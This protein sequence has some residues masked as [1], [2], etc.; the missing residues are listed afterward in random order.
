MPHRSEQNQDNRGPGRSRV[1]KQRGL[2]SASRKPEE[3]PAKRRISH[4][5]I[6]T[7]VCKGCVPGSRVQQ[8]LFHLSHCRRRRKELEVVKHLGYYLWCILP[9]Q[10]LS[11]CSGS[12]QLLAFDAD[13]LN[14]FHFRSSTNGCD[15]LAGGYPE[16]SQT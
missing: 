10:I 3:A 15:F 9:Y 11:N 16:T 12:S 5:C 6:L 4:A 14:H 1:H 2:K 8:A 7:A 13:V